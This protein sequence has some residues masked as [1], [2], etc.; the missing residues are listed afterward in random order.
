MFHAR[1]DAPLLLL[2]A[3]AV[4]ALTATRAAADAAATRTSASAT[5]ASSASFSPDTT[6]RAARL[7]AA[8]DP[9]SSGTPLA[10][11]DVLPVPAADRPATDSPADATEGRFFFGFGFGYGYGYGYK[12]YYY[13]RVSPQQL[14][15]NASTVTV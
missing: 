14:R 7:H 15:S 13:G 1:G 3:C 11:G 2:L 9:S 12:N 5:S 4:L 10:A 6:T 8:R